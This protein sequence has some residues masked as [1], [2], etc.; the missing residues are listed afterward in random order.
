M[1]EHFS[2]ARNNGQPSAANYGFGRPIADIVD[3]MAAPNVYIVI[4]MWML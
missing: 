4:A 3:H 2:N 1:I